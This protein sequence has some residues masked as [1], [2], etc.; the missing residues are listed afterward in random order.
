MLYEVITDYL[1]RVFLRGR[2][3]R[4]FRKGDEEGGIVPRVSVIA[5]FYQ[6][7][8]GVAG[9]AVDRIVAAA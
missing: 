1:S 6:R 3:V 9:R 5:V 2:A 7:I 8:Q 4:R